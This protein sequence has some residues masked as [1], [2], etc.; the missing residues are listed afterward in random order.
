MG[1]NEG[2]TYFLEIGPAEDSTHSWYSTVGLIVQSQN[3]YTYEIPKEYGNNIM[4]EVRYCPN[5][6]ANCQNILSS[7][8][9]AFSISEPSPS[10]AVTPQIQTA[11]NVK[12]TI[13]NTPTVKEK[14]TFTE[15][16]VW[17]VNTSQLSKPFAFPFKEYVGVTQW[18]GNTAFQKPH[19]GIDFGVTQKEVLAIGDGEVVGKGWDS[20]NGKC[21]SGGNYLLLKQTNGMYSVYF[22]LQD[23]Y[24]DVGKKVARSQVLGI[25]G[26]TG[27][28]NCQPLA[29]H[30]HLETRS[31]RSQSSHVNPVD[32]IATDWNKV[33]TL[34][35]K[36]NPGRL[37]GD[38]PHPTF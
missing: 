28:W 29:Y 8:T 12:A 3:S 10:I 5:G 38:N 13:K 27:S 14:P 9:F 2:Y 18:H 37:S 6:E 34:N 4:W 22:H 31:E 19:T 25:S 20:Y 33:F 11:S 16:M 1:A 23:I 36:S 7:K 21:M 32:Y 17:N 30:L 26:N 35:A 15:T 24:V